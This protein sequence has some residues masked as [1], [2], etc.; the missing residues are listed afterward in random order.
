MHS[1]SGTLKFL[2]VPEKCWNDSEHN[3]LLSAPPT[4][5]RTPTHTPSLPLPPDP[6]P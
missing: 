4:H 2:V 6:T 5:T 3:D 1:G